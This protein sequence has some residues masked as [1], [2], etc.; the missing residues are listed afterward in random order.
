MKRLISIM[1]FAAAAAGTGF[2]TDSASH[3]VTLRVDDVCRVDLNSTGG[4]T[5]A[6]TKPAA[7]GETP[8]G[9]TDNGK[10]LRYTSV[11]S[12]G[13]SRKITVNCDSADSAPSG[14]A[15]YLRVTSVPPRCGTATGPVRI[16]G[17]PREIITGIGSC[18]TGATGGG[19]RLQ[20]TLQ[21]D[22]AAALTAGETRTINVNFTLTDAS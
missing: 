6:V 22:D 4:I 8:A 14:T 2:A 20:Y 16:G 1:L 21:I 15:L 13:S 17:D 10:S 5:L 18:A 3:A 12:P 19:A 11:V 9:T 7:G